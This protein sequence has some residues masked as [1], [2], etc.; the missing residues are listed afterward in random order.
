MDS[1][2][3]WNLQS[4][5]TKFSKSRI[6]IKNLFPVC[7]CLQETMHKHNRVSLP[8]GYAAEVSPLTR[9][10][11]HERGAAILVQTRFLYNRVPLNTELQAVAIKM[12]LEKT[13]TICSLY[14]PHV[15]VTKQEIMNL[16]D[17]LELPFLLLGDMNARSPLWGEGITT[18]ERG[19]IFE[20]T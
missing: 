1:V 8:K 16:I 9:E 10:D 20:V 18:D 15:A 4:Y 12:H 7:I 3:Q 17:Q 5:R 11:G 14:L 13:Y 6:L 2:I 19:K